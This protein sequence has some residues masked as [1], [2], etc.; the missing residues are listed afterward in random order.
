VEV[1]DRAAALRTAQ[2]LG[3]LGAMTEAVDRAEHAG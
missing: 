1:P 2:E 3:V